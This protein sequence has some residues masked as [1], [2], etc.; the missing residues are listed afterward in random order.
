MRNQHQQIVHIVHDVPLVGGGNLNP[1]I[2]HLAYY[3][4]DGLVLLVFREFILQEKVGIAIL[5]GGGKRQAVVFNGAN[6]HSGVRHP[7]H[8][9]VLQVDWKVLVM[10]K[11]QNQ[12]LKEQPKLL[13][14]QLQQLGLRHYVSTLLP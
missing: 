12:L 8:L 7:S 1:H 11:D 3:G 6:N 2:L 5:D 14:E 10:G 4:N 13:K 9:E